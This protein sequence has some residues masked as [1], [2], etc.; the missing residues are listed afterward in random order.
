MR[1]GEQTRPVL[2]TPWEDEIPS[3]EVVPSLLSYS[4]GPF[5]QVGLVILLSPWSGSTRLVREPVLRGK[6]P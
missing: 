4:S 1:L 2:R 6:E 5:L 3:S